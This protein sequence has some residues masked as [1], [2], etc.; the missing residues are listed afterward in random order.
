MS[1]RPNILFLLS[2]QHNPH[3]AGFAGNRHARTQN[4]DHLAERGVVFEACYCQSP[5]CVPSRISMLTGQYAFRCSAWANSSVL[6]PDQ[7][8]LPQHLG[9]H[10]YTTALV[11]K[12]HLK[13]P[14]WDGG[15]QHR[16]YGDII[17]DRFCIHQPDPVETWDGRWCDHKV[18]RFPWAGETEIPESLLVDGVVTRESIAFLLEHVDKNPERP[19]FFCAGYG[20]PHFP[21]TAP[22]RYFRR[23]MADPPPLPPRPPGYPDSLHPH[24]RYIVDDFHIYDFSDEIQQ[25]TLAAYYACVDYLDDCIGELLD[26]LEREGLLEN[27]YVVY[28]SDHGDMAGEHGMWSKRTY[29]DGSARVPLV[30]AGPGIAGGRVV[31][32]PVELLDLFPTFC[33]LAGVPIPDDLDGETL[34][35]FLTADPARRRKRHARSEILMPNE[36]IEFRMARDARWK[37]VEFPAYPP[38]LFDMLNDPDETTNLLSSV[39]GGGAGGGCDAP[40]DE[41]QRIAAGGLS[42]AQIA[43]MREEESKRRPH[44]DWGGP[45]GPVQ[46]QLR[47]GRIVDA[48]IFLYPGLEN[49]R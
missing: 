22:G 28:A 19:W 38:V 15:F 3:I 49:T 34:V 11:G 18:G 48:D 46:Y 21:F 37:Y 30:I 45:H 5:L 47:D 7:L 39:S 27:T 23:A 43:A 36:R 1:N 40:L 12:M 24:D 25:R 13:A 35:P 29:Y 6:Y 4:L 20:R 31:R 10:G 8:T 17:I 14:R 42:W 33:E 9:E 16:P 44:F 41:L 32:E 2:D 26:R